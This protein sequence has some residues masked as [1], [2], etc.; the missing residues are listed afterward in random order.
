ML[1]FFS[2]RIAEQFLKGKTL[3]LPFLVYEKM[4]VCS[5]KPTRIAKQ[6]SKGKT[7]VLPFLILPFCS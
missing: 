6:F 7:L 2:T 3:V 5:G 4:L 1:R